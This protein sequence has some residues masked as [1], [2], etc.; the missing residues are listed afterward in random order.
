MY[1]FVFVCLLLVPIF[2]VLILLSKAQYSYLGWSVCGT[3][4][5]LE[6]ALCG[7]P[8]YSRNQ[9]TMEIGTGHTSAPLT[10]RS[11][12]GFHEDKR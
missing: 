8:M 6:C 1:V 5:T 12:N 9:Q 3:G 10:W 7:T 11:P 4:A 2:A